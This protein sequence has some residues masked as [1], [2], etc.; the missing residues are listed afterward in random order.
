MAIIVVAV[1]LVVVDFA[2]LSN[3][4]VVLASNGAVSFL[5]WLGQILEPYI[6]HGC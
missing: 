1:G 2:V 3:A 6:L 4:A 5:S